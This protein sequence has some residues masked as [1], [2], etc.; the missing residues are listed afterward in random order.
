MLKLYN[1]I[2]EDNTITNI[3]HEQYQECR[4]CQRI[5]QVGFEELPV[6]IQLY[7]FSFLSGWDL[8]RLSATC[9]YWNMLAND[10]LVWKSLIE[11]D[12]IK[13]NKVGHRS[14]PMT[15][16]E[17]DSDLTYKDIYL[18]CSPEIKNESPNFQLTNLLRVF[19]PKKAPRLV[20]FG[21]GLETNVSG[22]TRAIMFDGN[23]EFKITG[24]FPGEIDGVGSGFSVTLQDSCKVM[25]LITLYSASKR[26]RENR[27]HV[28]RAER[29]K[30]LVEA[31]D[32]G[33]YEVQDSIRELCKTIDGFIYIVESTKDGNLGGTEELFAMMNEGNNSRRVP[34]LVLSCIKEATHQRS[35]CIEVVQ[36]LKLQELNRPWLVHDTVVKNLDGV[37]PALNWL[38][39]AAQRT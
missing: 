2:L 7:I 4:S 18:R 13:W 28:N 23:P 30:L 19:M 5:K 38:I 14:N 27:N 37:V 16:I 21:P 24:M 20:M 11:R 15:Y 8:A 17:V 25:K 3:S 34:L 32:Q 26:E 31:S 35:P 22:I 1:S 10:S 6:Y 9:K 39:E 12:M 36:K 33:K 29:N